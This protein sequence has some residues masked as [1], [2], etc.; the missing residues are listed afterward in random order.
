MGIFLNIDAI[1]CLIDGLTL[2]FGG[3]KE[4]WQSTKA[5]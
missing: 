5:N 4:K 1:D 3:K 2:M